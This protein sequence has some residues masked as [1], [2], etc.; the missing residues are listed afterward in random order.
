MRIMEYLNERLVIVSKVAHT[1]GLIE[2][3]DRE[4]SPVTRYH[5]LALLDQ[6]EAELNEYDEQHKRLDDVHG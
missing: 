3:A 5:L 2:Q 4:N 1:R 6:Q